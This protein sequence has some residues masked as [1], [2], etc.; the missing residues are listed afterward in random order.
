MGRRDGGRGR[1]ERGSEGVKSHRNTMTSSPRATCI[2][3]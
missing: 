2:N 1:K 3:H